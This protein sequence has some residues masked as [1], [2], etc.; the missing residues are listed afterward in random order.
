MSG[1]ECHVGF[2]VNAFQHNAFQTCVN[3]DCNVAFQINAFQLDAFQT[4][5]VAPTPT[6]AVGWV[7]GGRRHRSDWKPER[8]FSRKYFD[9][10]LA[11][12]RAA[13]AALRASEKRKRVEQQEALEQAALAAQEALEVAGNT[14]DH[15]ADFAKLTRALDAAVSAKN[16]ATSLKRA[17]DAM[18]AAQAIIQEASD[19][20]EEE[21]MML[22]LLL[23]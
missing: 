2:Q 20:E 5:S 21:A 12:D 22:L 15:E 19:D 11:A 7:G 1:G 3:T 10:M 13:A 18:I 14:P 4:C 6:R 9:E 17:N 16:F 23:N 8:G